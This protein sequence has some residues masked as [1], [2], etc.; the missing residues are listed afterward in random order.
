MGSTPTFDTSYNNHFVAYG[1]FLVHDITFSLPVTDVGRTPITSCSCSVREPDRCL[2]IDTP[3]DDP[4]MS[5]QKCIATPAS[6]QAFTDQIC[7]LGVKDQLNGNSHFVDLSLTY[8]STMTTGHGLRT[9]AHG[10]LK[11]AKQP[12]SKFDLLPAQMD[13]KTCS[14]ST[15]TQRCFAGGDSRVMENILLSGLQAQWVRLHNVFAL[16]LEKIRP[17]LRDNDDVLYEEAKKILAAL[18][19]RYV[20]EDWLPMLIGPDATK[21]FLTDNTVFTRYDPTVPGVV[22]NE[23]ATAAIRL[24]TLVRDLFSRCRPN[25][26]FIDQIWLKDIAAKCKYAYDAQNNGV[27]SFL[28]GSLY[29]YGFAGDTN[30]A[31]EIHHH[32][33]ENRNSKGEVTR[34][35]IVSINICRGREHGLPGYN[36]YREVCGLPRAVQ[37]SDFADSMAPDAI[38]R[39]QTI[40]Q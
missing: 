27:D 30:Y 12:W 37:F 32:L 25:G 8:G 38:Q 1:Q 2:V 9:G 19:Q 5:Q 35:D 13:G 31:K 39:L 6:A 14:D 22:L 11:V 3:A 29:D 4:F 15:P 36:A 26:D 10:L 33:F 28:C 34:N 16:E 17:S 18:H 23:V 24:H 7:A 20:Y 40:Y 21:K